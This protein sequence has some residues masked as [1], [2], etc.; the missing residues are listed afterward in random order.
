MSSSADCTDNGVVTQDNNLL[1]DGND[2]LD[3]GFLTDHD[4]NDEEGECYF[5][6]EWL[7]NLQQTPCCT[8]LQAGGG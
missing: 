5:L 7:R 2:S 1:D 8:S 3:A 6:G 4:Q